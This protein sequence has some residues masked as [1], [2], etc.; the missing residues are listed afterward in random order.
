MEDTEIKL[1]SE[2]YPMIKKIGSGSFGEVYLTKDVDDN[3]L[4]AA[5]VEDKSKGTRLIEEYRI[6]KKMYKNGF[7]EGIPKINNFL[8]TPKFNILIMELCGNSLDA[9]FTKFNKGFDNGT[10]LKLG[11]DI[12]NLLEKMHKAGYIHRDIKPNN[13]LLGHGD[14]D[15]KLYVMD[16]GLSKKYINENE[17]I[18]FKDG[19]SLIGTARYASINIHMGMEPSRRDDLESVGY[20]LVYFLKGKLPWQGL[21]KK[22]GEDHLVMIGEVKM[23][24]N[25]E[26]LCKGV[27]D[28]F[29]DYLSYCR[30][31]KFD[32]KP[33]YDY[34]RKLLNDTAIKGKH[35]LKYIWN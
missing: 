4:Y 30:G 27:P 33:D 26:A 18:K 8:Q 13:F 17:H 22:K 19:K 31:L 2:N 28:C 29:R 1:L 10:V 7:T 32:E 20:M 9:M 21:K 11:I 6:Y 15:D 25:I 23:C 12:I 16:F 34:L 14:N 35:E 3:K 24:T 5:K